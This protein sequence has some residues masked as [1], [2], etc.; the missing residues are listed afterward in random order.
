MCIYLKE[1]KWN[2][3]NRGDAAGRNER[4][5]TLIPFDLAE[6][7]ASAQLDKEDIS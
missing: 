6:A 1:E 3:L 2:K 7:A 5:L 4:F